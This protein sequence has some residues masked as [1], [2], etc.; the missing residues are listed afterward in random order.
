MPMAFARANASLCAVADFPRNEESRV[1]PPIVP[2]GCV[3]CLGTLGQ[4]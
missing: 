2:N 4:P 3:L 1:A